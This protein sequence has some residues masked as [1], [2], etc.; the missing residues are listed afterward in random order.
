MP[1]ERSLR[2]PAPLGACAALAN[3][4]QVHT[5][6]PDAA[7]DSCALPSFRA[8]LSCTARFSCWVRSDGGGAIALARI[9]LADP[10]SA[11][12]DGSCHESGEGMAFLMLRMRQWAREI[13]ETASSSLKCAATC[14]ACCS[15][16]GA[17]FNA[18]KNTL[19][20]PRSQPCLIDFRPKQRPKPVP[21]GP[22]TVH[23]SHQLAVSGIS[24]ARSQR[25]SF[26]SWYDERKRHKRGS[27]SFV[28]KL[29]IALTLPRC[30]GV[31]CYFFL[32]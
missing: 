22:K 4:A 28:P 30:A 19:R 32:R 5:I 26:G 14:A 16:A 17:I 29:T 24:R 13:P 25:G 7:T 8:S 20:F 15:A 10:P 31:V 3:G 27:P 6:C 21:K 9:A 11:D 12:G 23:F 1:G 2:A 18:S